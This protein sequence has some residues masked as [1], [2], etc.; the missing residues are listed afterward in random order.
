[1]VSSAFKFRCSTL[2]NLSGQNW[3]RSR[4]RGAWP[5]FG[6]VW[7][8]ICVK[9]AQNWINL[10][11]AIELKP[12]F[13]N[14]FFPGQS[15]PGIELYT[16]LLPSSSC[17]SYRITIMNA[18]NHLAI[19]NQTILFFQPRFGNIGINWR[20]SRGLHRDM[21]CWIKSHTQNLVLT[22]EL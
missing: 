14:R 20:S 18:Y 1:M 21:V 6:S 7:L 19:R 13:L 16:M 3:P 15:N 10:T 22:K 4:F 12:Y 2:W 17:S 8:G 5:L 9:I 11:V